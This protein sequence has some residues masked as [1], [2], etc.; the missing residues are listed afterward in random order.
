MMLARRIVL[1]SAI[2]TLLVGL[3]LASAVSAMVRHTQE[4]PASFVAIAAPSSGDTKAQAL[5]LAPTDLDGDGYIGQLDLMYVMVTMESI[6]AGHSVED[7]NKDG[8]VNILD[9]AMVALKFGTFP[10]Q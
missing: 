1:I 4:L 9:L 10:V 5:Q 3:V 6:T 7:V 2:A 8:E